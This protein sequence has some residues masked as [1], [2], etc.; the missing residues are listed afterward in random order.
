MELECPGFVDSFVSLLK[1]SGLS[2]PSSDVPAALIVRARDKPASEEVI[3]VRNLSRR[4]GDFY[5]VRG[6]NFSVRRGEVF[7]LLGAN[8]AGK[9]TTFRMLYG[10]LPASEGMLRV[11][12]VDLRRA[13][14]QACGRVGYMAQKFSRY[15]DLSV[16]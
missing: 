7:G 4:F 2:A 1:S 10:L 16:I 11:A 15:G 12:G 5:A 3:V 9:S 14:A 13:A 6:V 8:G